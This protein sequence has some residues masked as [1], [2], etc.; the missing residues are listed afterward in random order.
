MTAQNGAVMLELERGR[1]QGLKNPC[2]GRLALQGAAWSESRCP[3]IRQMT[4]SS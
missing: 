4:A 1:G 2:H 3:E